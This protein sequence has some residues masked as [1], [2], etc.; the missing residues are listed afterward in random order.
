MLS[1]GW[2][3]W[4]CWPLA[5]AYPGA[6]SQCANKS[7]DDSI[8]LDSLGFHSTGITVCVSLCLKRNGIQL[9]A[10]KTDTYH[11]CILVAQSDLLWKK[12]PVRPR[13]LQ[14]ANHIL[15][16]QQNVWWKTQKGERWDMWRLFNT[17][18]PRAQL[19]GRLHKGCVVKYYITH[20]GHYC[21]PKMSTIYSCC[22]L[23]WFHR[24]WQSRTLT[25]PL[26]ALS[27][28]P[29]QPIP[30]AI[31]ISKSLEAIHNSVQHPM[32][33]AGLRASNSHLGM[34]PH[35]A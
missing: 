10:T 4:I 30:P 2:T 21:S 9:G 28:S 20:S 27:L 32:L 22:F 1:C 25:I 23:D 8:Q 3:C 17:E 15:I 26:F 33:V 6:H 24:R 12:S 13:Q 34:M 5:A 35:E 14:K 16:D 18:S 11:I 29:Q 19:E 7:S 31:A